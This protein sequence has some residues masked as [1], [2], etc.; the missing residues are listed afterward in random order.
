MEHVKTTD[1]VG[2]VVKVTDGI[3]H[4]HEDYIF[5]IEYDGTYFSNSAG[6]KTIPEAVSAGLAWAKEHDFNAE[7][8]A[9]RANY[10]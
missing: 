9:F 4:L 8:D 6:F 7:R 10:H 2:A 1:Q 5:L 3:T